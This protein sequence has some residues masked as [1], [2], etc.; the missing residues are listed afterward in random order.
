MPVGGFVDALDLEE[1]PDQRTAND[2]GGL[3]SASWDTGQAREERKRK[4]R[5]FALFPRAN[6]WSGW[7]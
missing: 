2:A 5:R 7:C 3:D 4:H 6:S 1:F